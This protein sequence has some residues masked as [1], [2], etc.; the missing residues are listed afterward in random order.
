MMDE[1]GGK[2]IIA[3][4]DWHCMVDPSLYLPLGHDELMILE[5]LS[6]KTYGRTPCALISLKTLSL[7]AHVLSEGNG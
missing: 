1:Y 6:S 4:T 7:Y 5:K 2:S 3:K